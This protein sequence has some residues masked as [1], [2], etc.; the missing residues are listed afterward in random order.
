MKFLT[1]GSQA[2]RTFPDGRA[3]DVELEPLEHPGPGPD[4]GFRLPEIAEMIDG[5]LG[6]DPCYGRRRA[7]RN[8]E[9]GSFSV[10]VGALDV[11]RS[12]FAPVHRGLA[13]P[14]DASSQLEDVGRV[15]R[16]RPRL[17]EVALH[18]KRPGRHAGT[19]LVLQ[20]TA[21][22]EREVDLRPPVDRQLRVEAAGIG[23]GTDSKDAAALRR[24]ALG[25]PGTREPERGSGHDGADGLQRVSATHVGGG[26]VGGHRPSLR[27][28]R[29]GVEGRYAAAFDLVKARR[30]RTRN[31]VPLTRRVG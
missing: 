17:G 27:D 6:H 16:L 11:V 20:Q 31:V 5:L 18:W 29:H 2:L 7:S 9:N 23:E 26:G 8:Q 19:G 1:Y 14:A 25:A 4:T 10:L 12:Q 3:A 22:G 15:A 30:S 21:V 24:L 28:V 13:V